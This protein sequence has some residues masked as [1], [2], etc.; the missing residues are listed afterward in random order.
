MGFR[1]QCRFRS[2]GVLPHGTPQDASNEV[3]LGPTCNESGLLAMKRLCLQLGIR[4]FGPHGGTNIVARQGQERAPRDWWHVDM[5][6]K[7]AARH[8][9]RRRSC[10]G[11]PYIRTSQQ[12]R[13]E[14]STI[15]PKTRLSTLP[16]NL[17]TCAKEVALWLV[18]YS[19]C[20]D[21][22]VLKR[23]NKASRGQFGKFWWQARSC[24]FSICE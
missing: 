14:P 6:S 2:V 5:A 3:H 19:N 12:S 7:R 4:E 9:Q 15:S 10:E 13:F 21:K 20:W 24:C 22:M 1:V 17:M 16:A 8:Q 23:T 11:C 18:K